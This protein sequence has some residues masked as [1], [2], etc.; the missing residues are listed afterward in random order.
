MDRRRRPLLA[1][2]LT[3]ARTA[4][5]AARARRPARP[6]P[7]GRVRS[8]RGARAD[9]PL[10]EIVEEVGLEPRDEAAGLDADRVRAHPVQLVQRALHVAGVEHRRVPTHL[11]EPIAAHA[12]QRVRTRRIL[13]RGRRLDEQREERALQLGVSR[14]GDG[15]IDRRP[16]PGRKRSAWQRR[17]A[18]AARLISG[19]AAPPSRQRREDLRLERLAGTLSE[20][21]PH[22]IAE[23]VLRLLERHDGRAPRVG[24]RRRHRAGCNLLMLMMVANLEQL[25]LPVACNS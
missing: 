18:A 6:H 7:A 11:G 25:F 14:R 3:R 19:R 17:R 24:L 23:H 16:H 15:R 2:A 13:Q 20:A 10:L 5:L 22:A 4:R 21:P 1:G 12:Q 8:G 9:Q